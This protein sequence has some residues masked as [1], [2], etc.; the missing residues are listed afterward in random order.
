[1]KGRE[2]LTGPRPLGDY[3]QETQE[4]RVVI[5][6]GKYKGAFFDTVPAGY[7]GRFLLQ[8]CRT[9]MTPQ[10]IKLCERY[11]G[12]SMVKKIRRR[13]RMSDTSKV[14]VEVTAG[15]GIAE[16]FDKA[17]EIGCA[18]ISL[19]IPV[20]QSRKEPTALDRLRTR[21]TPLELIGSCLVAGNPEMAQQAFRTCVLEHVY[22]RLAEKY[23]ATC[24]FEGWSALTTLKDTDVFVRPIENAT[25]IFLDRD[26][27]AKVAVTVDENVNAP[28]TTVEFTE[29]L[30]PVT[31]S[32]QATIIGA[33]AAMTDDV[34]KVVEEPLGRT[35][36]RLGDGHITFG[37]ILDLSS[38][39]LVSE[40]DNSKIHTSG[41]IVLYAEH[42][43][44]G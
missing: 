6:R 12:D 34:E 8:K 22:E 38:V 43:K 17:A 15:K 3:L 5:L 31:D 25:G 2:E 37:I 10:E 20:P 29:R 14:K 27:D 33:I 39:K 21:G 19:N 42:S 18:E 26:D 9:D 7:I 44:Q 30:T 1:M 23:N 35:L 16:A 36:A 32:I 24:V 11:A 4:G 28:V 40:A 41:R 13:V